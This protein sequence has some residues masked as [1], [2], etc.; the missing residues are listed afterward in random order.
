MGSELASG[1]GILWEYEAFVF[2]IVF[3]FLVASDERQR[4]RFCSMVVLHFFFIVKYVYFIQKK[5]GRREGFMDAWHRG[6]TEGI[7]VG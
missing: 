6:G 7:F 4:C 1:N 3:V 2:L 5:K